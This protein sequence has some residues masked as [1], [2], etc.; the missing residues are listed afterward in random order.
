MTSRRS[1]TSADIE[2]IAA[3]VAQQALMAMEVEETSLQVVRNKKNEFNTRCLLSW[4][5]SVMQ[6]LQFRSAHL[7][8]MRNSPFHAYVKCE[9][10][11]YPI[12]LIVDL[13][14][15]FDGE[16]HFKI[17]P[18]SLPFRP[19]DLATVMGIPNFG[20]PI[21]L[22]ADGTKASLHCILG[23]KKMMNKHN[24]HL[25]LREYI[26]QEGALAVEISVKL[27]FALLCSY[28][29][30]P[31]SGRSGLL[32][33]LPYL[34]DLH[35]MKNANWAAAIHEYLIS[36]VKAFGTEAASS[37]TIFLTGCVPALGVQSECKEEQGT[38][39]FS[40]ELG[41]CTD[42]LE[43]DRPMRKRWTAF[44]REMIRGSQ[45]YKKQMKKNSPSKG[46]SSKKE[47]I[48]CYEC[49]KPG[50]MR[51]ECPELH[52]KFKKDTR[53]KP[54]AMIATWSNDEEETSSEEENNEPS[55]CLMAQEEESSEAVGEQTSSDIDGDD[56]ETQ[57]TVGEQT[58][59]DVDGDDHV[60]DSF[61]RGLGVFDGIATDRLISVAILAT[62]L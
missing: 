21:N 9:M 45:H 41:S 28:F 44:H 62:D 3:D 10:V 38:P 14:T 52:K 26:P 30:F 4:Y 46:E 17:G 20:S 34:D 11:T 25:K 15:R 8:L 16:E 33:I 13:M 29:F 31:T 37:K 54:K 55:V 23:C 50:H 36:G 57:F 48:I 39:P 51:G 40:L 19:L 49:K 1:P 18:C 58:S 53:R 47:E 59:N 7:K 42:C 60:R 22:K 12:S 2:S 27:W 61:C 5:C 43:V 56:H 24:I 6:D 35:E 32:S